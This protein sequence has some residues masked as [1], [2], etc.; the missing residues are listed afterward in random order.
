M[1]TFDISPCQ[2]HLIPVL[3]HCSMTFFTFFRA[4]PVNLT[5]K[6]TT[7]NSSVSVKDCPCLFALFSPFTSLHLVPLLMC[8]CCHGQRGEYLSAH[9]MSNSSPAF[10]YF[11]L[12][13]SCPPWAMGL[14]I[15]HQL[16]TCFLVV[17]GKGS[18]GEVFKG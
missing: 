4:F 10:F 12:V 17:V 3:I 8:C 18:F 16:D 15:L 7:S 1:R 14:F 9:K 13:C 6:S 2:H 5:Q 11:L